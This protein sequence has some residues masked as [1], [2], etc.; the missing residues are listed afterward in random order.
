MSV[1][2]EQ[3]HEACL[4]VITIFQGQVSTEEVEEQMLITENKNEA[5]LWNGYP[6][7]S[8]WHRWSY[9][10]SLLG[11]LSWHSCLWAIASLFINLKKTHMGAVSCDG[12]QGFLHWFIGEEM[13]G[14]E[15]TKVESDRMIW[16]WNTSRLKKLPLMTKQRLLK[17]ARKRSVN[18]GGSLTQILKTHGISLILYN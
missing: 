8:R 18:K 11:A 5:S 3:R 13:G 4:T 15:F 10:K 1:A 6:I 14:V 17:M 16:C 2:H 12:H 9:E 7:A